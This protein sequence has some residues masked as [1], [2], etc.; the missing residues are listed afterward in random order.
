MHKGNEHE[1]FHLISFNRFFFFRRNLS[2]IESKLRER[3]IESER[4][5]K[6][7]DVLLQKIDRLE[8]NL[9]REG[10]EKDKL[11]RELD[12]TKEL[13]AK[14]DIEKEKLRAEVNEYAQIRRELEREIE[15][16]HNDLLVRHSDDKCIVERLQTEIVLLKNELENE[17]KNLERSETLAKEYNIQLRELRRKLLDDRVQ[18]D[19][20]QLSRS[21]DRFS[22]F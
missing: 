14:L 1:N 15:K 4:I 10:Q 8:V 17:K 12:A 16:M 6:D 13:C 7:K 18:Q 19:V 9:Q 21:N 3:E 2:T 20:K 11:K 5:Q 22:S